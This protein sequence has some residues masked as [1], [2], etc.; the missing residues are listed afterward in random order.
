MSDQT[1]GRKH[2]G[3]LGFDSQSIALE[4]K[5]DELKAWFIEQGQDMKGK[6]YLLAHADN[7]VIWGRLDGETL[8]LSGDAFEGVSPE[9]TWTTLQ[10]ARLF[11]PEKEVRVW[12]NGDGG[13]IARSITEKVDADGDAFDE[14]YVLWGTQVVDEPAKDFTKVS[15]GRRGLHHAVPILVPV[16]AFVEDPPSR[17]WRPLRLHV[18]H[19][20]SYDEDTGQAYVALSRLLAVDYEDPKGGVS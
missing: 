16:Q 9:L 18:R 12:R 6:S 15:E 2:I 4:Q 19:Y 14:A 10:Q 13:Y 17:R 5:S 1:K 20:L 7:G 11:S 8:V 3:N